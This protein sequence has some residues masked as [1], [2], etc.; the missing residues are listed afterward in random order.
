MPVRIRKKPVKIKHLKTKTIK[1][2][3]KLHLRI[4]KILRK[5]PKLWFFKGLSL[6]SKREIIFATIE[7]WSKNTN[8]PKLKVADIIFAQPC[9]VITHT[10]VQMNLA[11]RKFNNNA[12]VPKYNI[13]G[14]R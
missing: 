2:S 8:K 13:S 1:V 5:C 3:H 6:Q 9:S 10:I 12:S 14:T 4:N 7:Y 11:S